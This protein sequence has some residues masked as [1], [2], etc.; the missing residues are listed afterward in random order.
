MENTVSDL[1]YDWNNVNTSLPEIESASVEVH[2]ETLR[3]GV[4]SNG[5]T[6]PCLDK[7]VE[8]IHTMDAIGINSVC[9]GFPATS[10]VNFH[11]CSMIVKDCVEN[12]IKMSISCAARTVV[13][14]LF[15]IVNLSQK[16][17]VELYANIFIGSSPIRKYVEGW[18]LDYILECTRQSILFARNHNVKVC[19]ITEDTT[20][21]HPDDLRKIYDTAIECGAKRLCLCDTVGHS[22]LNGTRQLVHFVKDLIVKSGENVF[23][24]WHGHNDRGLGL[25]NALMAI[26]AGA[27]R[28]HATC[29]GIGERSGNTSMEQLLINLYLQ[30][31]GKINVRYIND[32][33]NIV[34]DAYSIDI[35]FNLPIVGSD[36]FSTSTGVHASAIRKADNMNNSWLADR[37]Y[38]SIPARDIGRTQRITIGPMSGKSNVYHVLEQR[39]IEYDDRLVESL[40]SFSKLKGTNLSDVEIDNII[41]SYLESEQEKQNELNGDADSNINKDNVLNAFRDQKCNLTKYIECL[42]GDE[43]RVAT[44]GPKGT[45]SYYAYTYFVQYIKSIGIHKKCSVVLLENFDLV[46]ETLEDNTADIIIIPNAYD[47]ITEMY[48]NPRL[49]NLFSFLLKT[50]DYGIASVDGDYTHKDKRIKI[51]SCKPVYCLIDEL[52]HQVDPQI[53]DYEVIEKYSTIESAVALKNH[54]VDLA[55]TNSTSVKETGTKFISSVW[56]ADVLW[57]VFSNRPEYID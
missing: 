39:K 9:I 30:N 25:A 10:A 49:Y 11:D 24:D 45:S 52:I 5:I 56:H 37:V 26:E 50:P 3:D 48:W 53:K 23:V 47:R 8:L 12:K 14:D 28:I 32:Y 40:L 41:N 29:L 17:G 38:S 21:S 1:I 51:A 55:L 20:R 4:Q 2:D 15:P 35:P 22:T 13:K 57:S 54:E 7:K 27:D 43:I 33:C 31:K 42:K 46:V 16:Y 19:F 36:V 18:E 34:K 6:Q 44:L